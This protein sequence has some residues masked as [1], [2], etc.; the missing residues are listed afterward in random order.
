MNTVIEKS[1]DAEVVVAR[2]LCL[3]HQTALAK[4]PGA[5]ILDITPGLFGIAKQFSSGMHTQIE[6]AAFCFLDEHLEWIK[7]CVLLF[8]F[9][10][11]LFQTSCR[12]DS[13]IRL[14][15]VIVLQF[16]DLYFFTR[17]LT[18]PIGGQSRKMSHTQSECW[19]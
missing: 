12:Y 4:G 9:V 13:C 19:T 3:Q 11:Y 5:T 17:R 18:N 14:L 1:V 6:G 10:S 8:F 2:G 7:D 16:R 15:N